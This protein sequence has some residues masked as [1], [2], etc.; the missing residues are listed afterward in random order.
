MKYSLKTK[1]G[2]LVGIGLIMFTVSLLAL[3][4]SDSENIVQEATQSSI[5][6]VEISE[7]KML[8]VIAQERSEIEW[9]IG[10]KL[11]P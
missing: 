5:Q 8:D 11:K 10:G 7:A 6:K 9:K 3:P 2:I 1:I 4:F